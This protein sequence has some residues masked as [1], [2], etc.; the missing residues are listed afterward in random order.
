[1]STQTRRRC[2]CQGLFE[3]RRVG[4]GEE[5]GEGKVGKRP[6]PGAVWKA[7]YCTALPSPSLPPSLPRDGFGSLQG[8]YSCS[9][10]GRTD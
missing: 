2:R 7:E 1:M 3:R 6:S 5:E 8:S 10:E 9:M 4:E